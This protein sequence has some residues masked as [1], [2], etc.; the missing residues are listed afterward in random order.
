MNILL[1]K[2]NIQQENEVSTEKMIQRD[3]NEKEG[4]ND[5]VEIN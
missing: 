3:L 2:M 1:M 4:I 5:I